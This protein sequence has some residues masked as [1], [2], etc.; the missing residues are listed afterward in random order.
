MAIHLTIPLASLHRSAKFVAVGDKNH[1]PTND[2]TPENDVHTMANGT[3]VNAI[4]NVTVVDVPGVAL[5]IA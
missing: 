1:A 2:V 5:A 3:D 4:G